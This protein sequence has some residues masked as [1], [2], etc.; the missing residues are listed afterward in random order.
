M[1]VLFLFWSLSSLVTHVHTG[2]AG[3]AGSIMHHLGYHVE[4]PIKIA[5]D[6]H[7]GTGP[8]P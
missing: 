7:H 8:A 4:M 2:G 6:D 3:A 5:F 1:Q